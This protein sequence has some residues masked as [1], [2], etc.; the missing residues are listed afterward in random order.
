MS[1]HI[2]IVTLHRSTANYGAAMQVYALWRYISSLGYDCEVVDILRPCHSRYIYSR[3]FKEKQS[4]IIR[5]VVKVFKGLSKKNRK[6]NKRMQLF[7]EFHQQIKYSREYRSLHDLYNAPPQYDVYVTG[8]DQVWN[9]N[10]PFYSGVYFWDFIKRK[11]HK[12]SYAASFGVDV[13]PE[14]C[15]QNYRSWLNTYQSLSVREVSGVDIIR[16]LTGRDSFVVLDPVFLFSKKEWIQC[17]RIYKNLPEHYVFL[18]LV[19]YDASLAEK[20]LRF[21]FDNHLSL[22][23]VLSQRSMIKDKRFKL[24]ENAGPYEWLYLI[25]HADYVLTDSFHG[26]SF[27]IIM[28]KSFTF[29]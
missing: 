29:V 13:I 9:P 19:R 22:Y 27:A 15:W 10:M 12:I 28:E 17:E 3:A 2:G 18:Y 8:S 21:A 16:Q 26:T 23:V 6:Q 11:V 4:G 5:R 25:N 20:S 7:S 1:K 24:I 14:S